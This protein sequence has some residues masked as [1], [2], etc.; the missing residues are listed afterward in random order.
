MQIATWDSEGK[1]RARLIVQAAQ[2]HDDLRE[3]WGVCE[4]LAEDVRLQRPDFATSWDALRLHHIGFDRTMDE[5][6]NGFLA[7]SKRKES[8][9]GLESAHRAVRDVLG[10]LISFDPLLPGPKRPKRVSRRKR[11]KT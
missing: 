5:L 10:T 7:S 6:G 1:V 9:E 11:L 4:N 3:K 2:M 8:R